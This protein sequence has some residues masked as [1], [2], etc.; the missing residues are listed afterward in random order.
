MKEPLLDTWQTHCQLNQDL[1]EAIPEED[2]AAHPVQRGR[3]VGQMLAHM[4]A[5]RLAWL[6]GYPDLAQSLQ[7]LD[8]E[9][10]HHK[11]HLLAALR[12]SAQA[13]REALARSLDTGKLKGF[14]GHPARFLAYLVAHESYHHGEICMTLTQSGHPLDRKAAYSLWAWE[15]RRPV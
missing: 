10:A 11:A 3:S 15:E 2:L 1:V 8:A 14:R 13:I 12:A 7:K 6:D 5:V 9:Q 4:H